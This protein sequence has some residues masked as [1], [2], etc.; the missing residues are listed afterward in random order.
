MSSSG[1]FANWRANSRERAR[2]AVSRRARSGRLIATSKH[3]SRCPE[4][5]MPTP[6]GYIETNQYGFLPF[7]G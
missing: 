6:S 1:S 4:L 2:A 3:E 5:G 7:D